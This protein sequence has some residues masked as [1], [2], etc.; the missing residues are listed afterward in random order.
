MKQDFSAWELL[1]G[2]EET[3]CDGDGKQNVLKAGDTLPLLLPF[4]LV[5]D[6]NKLFL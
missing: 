3:M 2:N 1:G 4:E 5:L 6:L